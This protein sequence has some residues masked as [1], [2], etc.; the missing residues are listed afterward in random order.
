MAKKTSRYFFLVAIILAVVA[1][2]LVVQMVDRYTNTTKAVMV[3]ETIDPFTRI[4]T[5]QVEL[6]HV[7]KAV[8]GDATL[9]TLAHAV[10]KISRTYIPPGTI[11][12]HAHLSVSGEGGLLAA[13]IT[14]QGD[15]RKRA[16]PIAIRGIDSLSGYLVKGDKVDIIAAM[17]LPVGTGGTTEPVSAIIGRSL[18]IIE[19]IYGKDSGNIEGVIVS[20]TPQQ[21]QE[22]KF[23]Q[24]SGSLTFALNP[25]ESD[26]EASRTEPTTAREFINKYIQQSQKG[27]ATVDENII[28]SD[29]YSISGEKQ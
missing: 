8:V 16:Y 12:T 1:S 3:K 11:L 22:V 24:L 7:P 5:A 4:K 21:A 13:N 19:I 9:R 10:G 17:K 2:V 18:E 6:A 23:A 27:G 26:I 15:P 14:E 29:E 28:V 25:Y 20:L